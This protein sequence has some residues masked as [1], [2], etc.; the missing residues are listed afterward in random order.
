[1]KRVVC[2]RRAHGDLPRLPPGALVSERTPRRAWLPFP[3]Q[4]PAFP[5][6]RLFRQALGQRLERET[7][8]WPRVPGTPA[9]SAD[10]QGLAQGE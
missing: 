9:L 6:L 4:A 1:M 8:P 5:R 10:S 2:Y 7:G 3:P